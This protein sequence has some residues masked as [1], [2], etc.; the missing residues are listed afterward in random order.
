LGSG[1]GSTANLRHTRQP[2]YDLKAGWE[3][4]PLFF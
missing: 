4:T 2:Q 3:E 1:E